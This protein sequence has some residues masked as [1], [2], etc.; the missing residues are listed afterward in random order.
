[1][2]AG[3]EGE[4][5]ILRRIEEE[6]CQSS[7]TP[8]TCNTQPHVSLWQPPTWTVLM[9]PFI[10]TST[11]FA[12]DLPSN[13]HAKIGQTRTASL[14]WSLSRFSI[15]G[16]SFFWWEVKEGKKR[17]GRI[18]ESLGDRGLGECEGALKGG[19]GEYMEAVRVWKCC[20][21]PHHSISKTTLQQMATRFKLSPDI[22]RSYGIFWEIPGIKWKIKG[23][24]A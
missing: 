20:C 13:L 21:H 4:G 16:I 7:H 22:N 11:F 14:L 12:I 5:D 18:Q 6:T 1:M 17:K 24:L 2:K 15:N 8:H 23:L 9:W 10:L 19:Q 3:S